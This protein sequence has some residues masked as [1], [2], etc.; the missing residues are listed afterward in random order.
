MTRQVAAAS[1][2]AAWA[3]PVVVTGAARAGQLGIAIARS[4]AE[5]GAHVVIVARAL[6]DARARAAEL[7]AEGLTVSPFECDLSDPRA[8][9]ALAATISAET[10]DIAAL[11]NAAGGFVFSGPVA[12]ADPLVPSAQ[13]TTSAL[14]AYNATQAFLPSLRTTRG[15]IV[16]IASAAVLPGGR[17]K[18][19][20][21]YAMAKAG[22]LA[23][24]RAVAQEEAANGVRS[25]AIAPG[26]VRTA[27]NVESMAPT[28]RYVEPESVAA[29]IRFLCSSAAVNVTGQVVEV[30]P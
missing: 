27:S 15:S 16:F 13:F 23:L 7:R 19:V 6:N 20:S 17:A 28:T 25:N 2:P 3:G 12:D 26:A 29:V 18:G 9:T 5:H 11:I 4:F 24:M 21:A 14:T 1:A 22:V 30:A 10:G 8:T